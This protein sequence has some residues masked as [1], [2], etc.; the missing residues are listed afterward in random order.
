MVSVFEKVANREPGY[1]RHNADIA[2]ARQYADMSLWLVT[3]MREKV[4]LEKFQQAD[5]TFDE[6][7]EERLRAASEKLGAALRE[8]DTVVKMLHCR[9]LGPAGIGIK[10]TRH[11]REGNVNERK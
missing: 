10:I 7:A 8:F 3:R 1:K 2:A 4:A 5:S 11:L 9:D 6:L